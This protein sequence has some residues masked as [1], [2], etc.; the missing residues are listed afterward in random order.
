MSVSTGDIIKAVLEF[1]LYDGTIIQN[2]LHFIADFTSDQTDQAVIDACETYAEGLYSEIDQYVPS[3]TTVNDMPVQEVEWNAEEGEW[4]VVRLLGNASPTITFTG[5]SDGLP[6]QCSAVLVGNT[7]RPKSRGRKFLAP[8]IETAAT[9]SEWA[10]PVVT[11][12]GLALNSYLAD[13][14]VSGDNKLS[15]GVPRSS[16]NTFLEFTNGVVD[17]IVGSQRRRKPGEGA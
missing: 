17:S 5:A 14:T 12:L 15:P 3:A 7:Q 11:A 10:A 13:E 2:I 16:V 1:V 9:A 6:N 8:F 4:L